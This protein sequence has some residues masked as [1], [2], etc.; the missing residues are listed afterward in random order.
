LPP[1]SGSDFGGVVTT[2]WESVGSGASGG[3]S[4]K[5]GRARDHSDRH[6]GDYPRQPARAALGAVGRG[7][8]S[9]CVSVSRSP[10]DARFNWVTVA[11]F[12]GTVLCFRPPGLFGSERRGF[13]RPGGDGLGNPP[14]ERPPRRPG[15]RAIP[16]VSGSAR[17]VAWK[18]AVQH[19]GEVGWHA[20]PQ[21]MD[22]RR[23]DFGV[24]GGRARGCRPR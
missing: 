16:G 23:L 19:C 18:Q 14:P 21:L 3:G 13:R 9:G 4:R 10:L 7:S 2:S 15:R 11:A 6:A 1:C 20:R 24:F 12:R 5:M 22:V 8:G 17:R